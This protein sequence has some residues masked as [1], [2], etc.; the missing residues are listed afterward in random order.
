ML[1]LLVIYV[2]VVP[3]LCVW[4]FLLVDVSAE[5]DLNAFVKLL[6]WV[7]M[8]LPVLGALYY[9]G[10]RTRHVMTRRFAAD[11]VSL[12][13]TGVL[14]RLG[15]ALIGLLSITGVLVLAVAAFAAFLAL[16]QPG[17]PGPFY[18]APSPLP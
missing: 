17:A 14:R 10:I 6:F 4:A 16:S 12:A 9:L 5:F 2:V 8:V 3:A 7:V 18:A 11:G 13:T 1:L 15:W